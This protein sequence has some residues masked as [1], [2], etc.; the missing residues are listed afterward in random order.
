MIYQ[1]HGQ[2]PRRQSTL[3]K[4]RLTK[5]AVCVAHGRVVN[6]PTPPTS[7]DGPTQG[8]FRKGGKYVGLCMMSSHSPAKQASVKALQRGGGTLDVAPSL[9]FIFFHSFSGGG[10]WGEW[11]RR[12]GSSSEGRGTCRRLRTSEARSLLSD[13]LPLNSN[14]SVTNDPV[15]EPL[16][17]VASLFRK[18]VPTQI[19]WIKLTAEILDWCDVDE[20]RSCSFLIFFLFQQHKP[21]TNVKSEKKWHLCRWLQSW[22]CWNANSVLINCTLS[23]NR[24]L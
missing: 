19:R 1:I 11:V 5:A 8:H 17:R 21:Q 23:N 16:Q 7:P 20:D 4:R 3:R 10:E 18:T 13:R 24:Y 12:G 14:R 9:S 15:A 2:K 6:P 22:H